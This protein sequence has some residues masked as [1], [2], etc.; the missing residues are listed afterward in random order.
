MLTLVVWIQ[1]I[2]PSMTARLR[3]NSNTLV[4]SNDVNLHEKIKTL[5]FGE[6]ID[7]E[8]FSDNDIES[9]SKANNVEIEKLRHKNLEKVVTIVFDDKNKNIEENLVDRDVDSFQALPPVPPPH[10]TEHESF[11]TPKPPKGPPPPSTIERYTSQEYESTTRQ[12][13]ETTSHPI[14]SQAPNVNDTATSTLPSNTTW[15]TST[16]NLN[17]TTAADTTPS[18]NFSTPASTATDTTPGDNS[19]TQAST[20]D[21]NFTTPASTM[22]PDDYECYLHLEKN[23]ETEITE[24]FEAT[25]SHK[26]FD[27]CLLG[28]T[29]KNL[30]WVTLEGKLDV[31]FASRAEK[32]L[33]LSRNF[34]GYCNSVANGFERDFKV[35]FCIAST[36]PKFGDD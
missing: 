1:N 24:T 15:N 2:D 13:N 26:T 25:D 20:P 7:P 19:T 9:L 31:S 32:T 29:E 10:S 28:S 3:E 22:S 18:G 14:S 35:S 27:E 23:N 4:P 6:E 16:P 33:D 8:D 30:K 34:K 12:Q 36:T 21:G 17:T 5:Y 11:D